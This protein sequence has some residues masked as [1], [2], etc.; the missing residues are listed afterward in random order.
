MTGGQ[1]GRIK[2]RMRKSTVVL[3]CAICCVWDCTVVRMGPEML[4]C[5]EIVSNIDWDKIESAMMIVHDVVISGMPVMSKNPV[6]IR[7]MMIA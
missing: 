4:I 3:E 1:I 2:T 7:M 5:A 6:I